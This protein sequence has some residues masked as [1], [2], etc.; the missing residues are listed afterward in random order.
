MSKL[1]LDDLLNKLQISDETVEI[2]VKRAEEFGNNFMETVSA[3]S[4]EPGRNGGYILL[5]IGPRK[6]SL[7]DYEIIGIPESDKMQT[8]F[9]T[10]CREML[11]T[12]IRPDISIE[13]Y[14][15]KTVLVA[16][17]PEAHP[18][19]KPIYIKSKGLPRGA[20]RRIGSTDQICT[21]DDIALFYQL[22]DHRTYDET[23]IDDA[24]L[25][26]LD[27]QAVLEYRRARAE[28]N[29]NALE[30][31]YSDEEL[32]YSLNTISRYNNGYC[33]TIAGLILFGKLS[34]LR[35]HF[36][37]ARVDYIRVEGREWVPD[38]D[39][40]YQTVEMIGPLLTLIP[41]LI[42]HVLDDIPKVFTLAP[43]AIHRREIPI[44]PRT[45]IREAIVNAL[46]HR[47]YRPRQP[48]Q[49][50]R[51]ANRIEIRN[52]GYS[53]IPDDRL[54]E[55]GSLTR[56]EKIAAVLHEVGLAE[57]KGTGIRVMRD[58]MEHSNLTLPLFESDRHKDT[59]TVT[60]LVHHLFSNEDIEWLANFKDFNLS[61]DEARALVVVREVGAINNAY[62][63][64]INHVD[65]LTASK[66][67]QRLRDFELLEQ[68]GKGAATYY[69]PTSYLS[70]PSL[71]KRPLLGEKNL[72]DKEANP[73]DKEA[74]L[75]D[76]EANLLAK[77]IPE[78]L[79][80]AIE[81]LGERSNPSAVREVV[82]KLCGWKGLKASEI[83]TLLGRNKDYIQ[84]KF[85]LPM[86][87][88]GELEYTFPDNPSHPKQAYRTVSSQ[89]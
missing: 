40:R 46:M 55:P 52:P 68:K 59:F 34:S 39:H 30:L 16:Y 33:P 45:V 37:L 64:T 89:S 12:P 61:S 75:L 57:T 87:Q 81:A 21:E 26:D 14:H 13:Q 11:N 29:P 71:I 54:G 80:K 47:N 65:T 41:R 70:N 85:L 23:K 72:L 18:Y 66:Q 82:R 28:I 9:A 49:I 78:Y 83:A 32:L 35:R 36:P 48:V 62:Y 86:I 7:S 31:K 20:F 8:E 38:P 69:V 73:L 76:K 5:G 10:K 6:D 79:N 56:N 67:L 15:G 43:D 22:R 63:R 3:F 17:I 24:T 84:Y 88:E 2:E 74:N 60:L 27:A 58:M 51:Y 50:I 25:E 77:E 53:L 4:N 42:G 44:I 1:T 19:E